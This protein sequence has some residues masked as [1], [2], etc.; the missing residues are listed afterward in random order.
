MGGGNLRVGEE[1]ITFFLKKSTF[2]L[3]QG[4]QKPAKARFGGLDLVNF[5]LR[6]HGCFCL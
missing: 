1:E 6:C 3:S 2:D 5:D 4:K